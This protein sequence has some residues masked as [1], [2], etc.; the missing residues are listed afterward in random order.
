MAKTIFKST[1]KSNFILNM[2]EEQ[3]GKLASAGLLTAC[4]ATS[5][6]TIIPTVSD[7][8]TYTISASGLAVSGVICMILA[9]IALIKRYVSRSVI[10]PAAAFG[11]MLLWGVV[12]LIFSYD[13]S[14]SFYGF[15][16]RGEGLL[17]LVFYFGFFVTAASIKRTR[18]VSTLITGVIGVG[19]LNSVWSLIQL[20]AD[21][22]S[23][24]AYLK[25]SPYTNAPA[26][27]G[28]A[29]SPIFLAMLLSLSLTAAAA[30]CVLTESKKRRIF[31][32][33]C[34]CLFSFVLIFTRTIMGIFGVVFGAAAVIAAVFKGKAPKKMLLSV[35]AVI[36]SAA[37]AFILGA[38]AMSGAN[39]G[40]RLYDG[41]LLWSDD[42][43]QRIGASGIYNGNRV[44][45]EDPL[46]V[47]SFLNS[48]TVGIIKKYP[49]TGTGPEQLVYPQI[50]TR[51]T[52]S[53][54]APVSD[55]AELNAGTFDKV[56]NEYLYTAA[57]R[58]IPSLIALLIVIFSIFS[59]MRK[60]SKGS[61]SSADLIT[62]LLTVCGALV[63]LIGCSNITFS[64]IF[65]ACAGAACAGLK[66]SSDEA[67]K[68]NGTKKSKRKLTKSS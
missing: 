63:F 64:P 31:D 61:G 29:Q 59:I 65:W 47:Y 6:F 24:F 34:I 8:S 52:F 4:F 37:A 25:I 54:D 18:A 10:L 20:F 44:D 41:Y 2:T 68:K 36:L 15:P 66:G 48:E 7:T 19:L 46:D 17:A 13:L 62:G 38:T 57:T 1:E 58:G 26:A 39:N 5:L 56:Y 45:I 67:E 60:K 16:Q 53:E 14:V 12:S 40:Y 49:L 43:F 35:L 9:L 50:Y 23:F 32:I 33:V 22:L 21:A 11:A 30:D 42:S 27:S 28:L 55:F 3:Y 51:G